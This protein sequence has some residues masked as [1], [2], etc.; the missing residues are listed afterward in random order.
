MERIDVKDRKILYYLSL[1]SRQS[2]Q[3]IGRIVGLT[4][5]VVS[6]RIKRMQELGIIENFYTDFILTPVGQTIYVRLYFNYQN[7]TPSIKKEI[8]QYF[9]D[10]DEATIVASLEGNYDLMVIVI[11]PDIYKIHPYLEHMLMNYGDYFKERHAA[12]YFI[13]NQYNPSFLLDSKTKKLE[14][15]VHRLYQEISYDELDM[16]ILK[17]LDLNARMPITQLADELHST[18]T[19]I[20]YRIKRLMK[21]GVILGFGVN[22]NWEKL[23]YRFYHVEINLKQYHKRLDIVRYLMENPYFRSSHQLLGHASDLEVDFILE[24]VMQLHEMMDNLSTHFP[25]SVK[26]FK[27]WS[28]LKTYKEQLFPTRHKN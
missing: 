23:G 15:H 21:L 26:D 4:K 6:Y 24:N 1:N 22:I 19:V 27:Y 20:H 17:A 18:V 9:V 2:L 10:T 13:R 8:I 7:I 14:P 28:I 5:E 12:L 16:N 11:F 3:K 25:E